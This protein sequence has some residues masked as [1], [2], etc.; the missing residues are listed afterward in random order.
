MTSTVKQILTLP[1]NL[2]L[3][4][5][6]RIKRLNG[7]LLHGSLQANSSHTV[8][9]ILWWAELQRKK[10]GVGCSQSDVCLWVDFKLLAAAA[11]IS[12][13]AVQQNSI[14]DCSSTRY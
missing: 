2:W 9:S 10:K 3:K 7:V 5:L 14:I 1:D 11:W 6:N 8:V 12:I 4:D 13:P